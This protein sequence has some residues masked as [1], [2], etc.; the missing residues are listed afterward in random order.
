[1]TEDSRI[2]ELFFAHDEQAIALLSKKYGSALRRVAENILANERDAEECVNDTYLAVWNA[3]PPAKPNPLKSFVLRILRNISTAR[4]HSNTA[5]KR[6]SF[7]DVALD[8]LEECLADFSLIER[9]VDSAE[10]SRHIDSF[11]DTLDKNGRVMFMLRYWSSESIEDIAKKFGMT[12][13]NVSVRLSRIREKLKK[14]LKKEGFD[15]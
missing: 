4:Y 10:L 12:D 1:M 2:I 14:H 13:H 15:L 6:N 5:V 11:L 8:E 9:A 7:Y 3:I